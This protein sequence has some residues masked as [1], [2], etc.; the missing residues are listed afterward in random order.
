MPAQ[1]NT[2]LVLDGNALLH[3]AWHALPQTMTTADGTVVNAAY[4]F[5]NIVERMLETIK[6]DYMAVA[7][8][9]PGPTFRH[10]TFKAYKATRE[11]K[12]QELYDQI[13][14][15]QD[16][17]TCYGIPSLSKAS[18]EADDILG[19]I[20]T[21]AKKKKARTLIVTGDLDS[22]QLVDEGTSV[23]F[24]IKGISE[25]KTYDTTAVR[26]RY[27]FDPKTLID[28]KA[29][30]GD[31][32]DNIA[33][34]PGIG[35][36]SAKELIAAFGSVEGIY[37][38]LEK[39]PESIKAAW[40]AKLEGQKDH[41]LHMRTIVTIV[42]DVDL[43]GFSF[44]DAKVQK[45]DPNCLIKKFRELGFRTLLK[46]YGEKEERVAPTKKTVKGK[47]AS[48]DALK[49]S[50]LAL[51]VEEQSQ[52]LFG[53]TVKSVAISDGQSTAAFEYPKPKELE[54]IWET[55]EKADDL[56]CHNLKSA[57]HALQL[58]TPTPHLPI[59][60]DTRL[61]A[62]LLNPGGRSF[63]LPTVAERS[64][65]VSLPEQPTALASVQTL[66]RLKETLDGQLKA[67]KLSHILSDIEVPLIPVLYRMERA[68]VKLDRTFLSD[69]SEKFH[70][71]LDGLTEKIYRAAGKPF[72]VNS[73]SQ[74][75]DILFVDLQINTKGIKKT[76]TT[77][78]TAVDE[79]EKIRDAHPIVP[80]IMD[81]RELAKLTSTYVD[82]L[83]LLVAKDG[84]LHTTYE[85]VVAATGRLSSLNPNLQNIPIRTEQGREIRKAF[86]AEKGYVLVT[87][88]YSQIELRIAAMLAG[89]QAF[90]KAFKEGADI[91]T[92]TAAEAWGIPEN[93]VTKDQRRAAKAVNF[94]ILYG[95]GPRNLAKSTGL[96]LDE[97]RD[98][99]DRY[100]SLHGAIKNYIDETKEKAHTFGYVETL[101][102][103]KRYFPE[104][105]SGIQMLVAQAERMAVNMPMQGTQAD[106]IKKAMIEIDRVLDPK[107]ARLIL[108]VHDELVLEVKEEAAEKIG[109]LVKEK[110]EGI[111]EWDVPIIADVHAGKNWGEMKH[112]A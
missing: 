47:R 93:E 5:T 1:K 7:W 54:K 66:H 10:E 68:G 45:P 63:D 56:I 18:Y 39:N 24:F 8:D 86:V 111:V 17:L 64:L 37:Q 103:R 95:M 36:K 88:D 28:Y 78:S 6:P 13:P 34:V 81:Y 32:S 106:L 109:N 29:L 31:T 112:V 12:E 60:F 91:H 2:F 82:A 89:D 102:G 35:E 104:I 79:L 90:L 98:F 15:I 27:G 41:A 50:V 23:L 33:G 75:S 43:N 30:V 105:Q 19:T 14:I 11:K 65:G 46:K 62:Y 55:I 57:L 58:P 77:L 42:R 74:L 22:L 70:K 16:I 107:E 53:G 110:M 48:I 3:R 71:D 26:E 83:P 76:K 51:A 52:D 94:G 99:I 40:R 84:R 20:A 21:L 96:S 72:N 92:R 101:F 25:T 108:Q 87:A 44:E 4:G 100:F 9:L 73:P 38:A 85:Q 80:L 67:E 69:L 61:A 59:T 97:A 49:T